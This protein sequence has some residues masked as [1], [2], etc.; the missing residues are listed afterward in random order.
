MKIQY[1]NMAELPEKL[2][3]EETNNLFN[4]FNKLN[5][6]KLI[7]GHLRLIAHEINTAFNKTILSNDELF[8]IGI[9]GLIKAVDNYDNTKDVVFSTYA[10]TCI[11]NSILTY[12]NKMNNKVNTLSLDYTIL[13]DD[14]DDYHI[15]EKQQVDKRD[16]ISQI[17]NKHL[18]Q[19]LLNNFPER[20]Q[21][22][23]I[24]YYGLF[25]NP[26]YTQE[27]L[28]NMFHMTQGN[29]SRIIINALKDMKKKIVFEEKKLNLK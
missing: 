22:I 25:D 28:A 23:I 1:L 13:T 10:I 20:E 9:M 24:L 16:L 14:F 17:D 27:E 15:M 8:E 29:I 18:I 6:Q 7:A 12:I 4:N 3:Q 21:R 5:R 11:H 19:S 2:E 26:R